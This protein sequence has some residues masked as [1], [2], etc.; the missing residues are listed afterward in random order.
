M[1]QTTVT[2]SAVK[3]DTGKIFNCG[4]VAT[5]RFSNLTLATGLNAVRKSALPIVSTTLGNAKIV[6]AVSFPFLTSGRPICMGNSYTTSLG[7]VANTTLKNAGADSGHRANTRIETIHQTTLLNWT[8]TTSTQKLT[9]VLSNSTGS[10]LTDNVSRPTAAIPGR[11]VFQIGS[12]TPY[13][14][15]YKPRSSL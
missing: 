5:T 7:G 15:S 13:V 3:R 12:N 6:S 8:Y 11:L 1:A 10:F 4:N 2:A 9:Y 14:T